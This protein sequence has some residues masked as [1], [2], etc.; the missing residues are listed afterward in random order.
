[1]PDGGRMPHW[2]PL[3]S[4]QL[5]ADYCGQLSVG[6]FRT[7]VVPECPAVALSAR[8]VA[9]AKE[10][11]DGWI[12]RRRGVVAASEEKNPWDPA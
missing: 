9:W 4:E 8:R 7:V 11:L 5:A 6:T 1:M 10:D 3:M 2:P 12:A